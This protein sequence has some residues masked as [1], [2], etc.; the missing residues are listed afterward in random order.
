M[1]RAITILLFNI[2]TIGGLGYTCIDWRDRQLADVTDPMFKVGDCY[3]SEAVSHKE[4]WEDQSK[5]VAKVIEVGKRNYRV[6]VYRPGYRKPV[7]STH[8]FWL[9]NGSPAA[10]CT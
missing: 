1:K 3:Y 8:S 4:I 10:E 9:Y 6:L 2:I 5:V 7:E